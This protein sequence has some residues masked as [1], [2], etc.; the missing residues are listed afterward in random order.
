MEGIFSHT[1]RGN[2]RIVSRSAS[3]VPPNGRDPLSLSHWGTLR[4]GSR[5]T[6]APVQ[7]H[8][9][10]PLSHT[11]RYLITLWPLNCISLCMRILFVWRCSVWQDPY[12]QFQCEGVPSVWRW[13]FS[14]RVTHSVNGPFDLH[15][16][17]PRV[18]VDSDADTDWSDL[19]VRSH[20]GSDSGAKNG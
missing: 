17:P 7:L 8:G 2:L 19:R 11:T 9:R 4:V 1:H 15:P 6:R 3:P 12:I 10:D 16:P 18:C 5:W 14:C 13:N 20:W